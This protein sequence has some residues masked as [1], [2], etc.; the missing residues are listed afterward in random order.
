MTSTNEEGEPTLLLKTKLNIPRLSGGFITRPHLV[1]RLNHNLDCKLTLISAPAGYGKTTLMAAWLGSCDRPSA[2]FSLDKNDNDLVLFLSY[3]ATAIRSV[4]PHSCSDTLELLRSPQ[5]PTVDYL[6]GTLTNE[7]DDLPGSIMLALDDYHFINEKAIQQLMAR[8]INYQP[9]SLHLVIATRSDPLLPLPRL[10]ADQ[11]I[12]E[13]RSEDLRFS[14]EEAEQFLR[15]ATD[16]AIDHNTT[17]AINQRTEGWVA[18]MQLAAL[19]IQSRDQAA[20]LEGFR[21]DTNKFILEYL[22]NEVLMGQPV[23]VQQFLLKTA[24]LERFCA[25]LCDAITGKHPDQE[26]TILEVLKRANLFLI[27]LDEKGYWFRYHHLF[28]QMLLG[29]LISQKSRAEIADLHLSASRWLGHHGYIEEAL[30]HALEANDV[31]AASELVEENSQNLLNRLERHTLE[32]WLSMLPEEAIWVRS[33]LLVAQA[34]LLYRQWHLMSMDAVLG[35]AIAA[36]EAN[37]ETFTTGE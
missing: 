34:W 33:K 17:I 30:H 32:R 27:P 9:A 10:R 31:Q 25:D 21:G 7:I 12:F 20:F 26:L 37:E 1:E 35:R 13:L 16:G 3:F 4:F 19:S 24:I 28:Q 18:G 6:A 2:W 23:D 36:L 5:T 29:K 22:V 11:Q 14:A 8:L 15:Y